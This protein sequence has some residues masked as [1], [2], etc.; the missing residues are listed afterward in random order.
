MGRR[1]QSR[2]LRRV[3][4]A[5]VALSTL[6]MGLIVV[7]TRASAAPQYDV[8][9]LTVN[10]GALHVIGNSN[11]FPN[12]RTGAVDNSYAYAH[13]HV[14]GSPFSQ[15]RASPFDTGP[16]AQ[17]EAAQNGFTQPQYTDVR[18]PPSN[19]KPEEFGSASGPLYAESYARE[20]YAFAKSSEV[21]STAAQPQTSE[22]PNPSSSVPVPIPSGSTPAPAAPASAPVI[23]ILPVA[24]HTSNTPRGIALQKLNAF[25]LAWRARWL[26]A[27]DAQR[28]PV[29]L[30]DASQPDGQDGVSSITEA[31][32]NQASGLLTTMGDARAAFVSLGGGAI[33][34][35]G[36]HTTTKTT[37]DGSG[38]Q[39]TTTIKVA[40]AEIGGV[41][42]TI[43][44]NGVSVAGT[45]I[46]GIADAVAQATAALNQGLAQAGWSINAPKPA[47]TLSNGEKTIDASAVHVKFQEPDSGTG[48]PTLY[49]EYWI[50][51]VFADSLG[52]TSIPLVGGTGGGIGG[53]SVGGVQTQFIPG[54]EGTPGSPG[55][56]GSQ[57]VGESGLAHLLRTKPLYLLLLYFLWQALIIGTGASLWWLRMGGKPA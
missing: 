53:P 21:G 27:D 35:H 4:A 6:G 57:A 50:G 39:S 48:V 14:D 26:T 30:A 41:P 11:A 51:Q 33:V 55:A 9:N 40:S 29:V 8:V 45:Q 5:S 19:Q 56:P 54:T 47:I 2:M 16:A 22:S 38:P 3:M 46:P 49:A 43:D 31:D 12:F 24:F 37:D 25:I 44:Q 23:K 17:L 32:F 28:F 52:I 7:A 34:L 20:N 10:A 15:G 42:V 36:V 18:Y 13:A 1:E